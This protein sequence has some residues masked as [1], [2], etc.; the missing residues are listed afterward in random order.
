M[1]CTLHV[2]D[3]VGS[4]YWYGTGAGTAVTNTPLWGH[5]L[6]VLRITGTTGQVV[7]LQ[8]QMG[9]NLRCHQSPMG[10]AQLLYPAPDNMMPF[11]IALEWRWEDGK[12]QTTP[13]FDQSSLEEISRFLVKRACM[14]DAF[15]WNNMFPLWGGFCAFQTGG[16]WYWYL[17]EFCVGFCLNDISSIW[18]EHFTCLNKLPCPQVQ[19][20][21]AAVSWSHLDKR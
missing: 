12:L 15:G 16:W 9:A 13:S 11:G 6:R 18:Q 20:L 17:M 4:F 10:M 19:L 3:K 14:G 21:F 2:W 7:D 1:H 5:T 8:A